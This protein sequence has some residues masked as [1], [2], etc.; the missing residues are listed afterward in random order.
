MSLTIRTLNLRPL[1]VSCINCFQRD[2]M[3]VPQVRVVGYA[4]EAR[5]PVYSSHQHH[6]REDLCVPVV[7]VHDPQHAHR[8]RFVSRLKSP[9]NYTFYA[10]KVVQF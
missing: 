9:Q 5:R 6:Q 2:Q 3:H 7:L 1:N 10:Y 8:P 4:A